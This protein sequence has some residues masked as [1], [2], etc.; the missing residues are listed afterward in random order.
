MLQNWDFAVN[1]LL[2]SHAAVNDCCQCSSNRDWFIF[3]DNK[4]SRSTTWP[5]CQSS[6]WFTDNRLGQL[7]TQVNEHPQTQTLMSTSIWHSSIQ[8]LHFTQ[9]NSCTDLSPILSLTI[10]FMHKLHHHQSEFVARGTILLRIRVGTL[11]GRWRWAHSYSW[12]QSSEKGTV[13]YSSA[14]LK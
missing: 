6:D 14:A 7:S 4:Y 13:S 9:F 5:S 3:T 2:Y 10:A 8:I 11:N 1:L 12:L